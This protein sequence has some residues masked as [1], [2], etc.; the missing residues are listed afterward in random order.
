MVMA[1]KSISQ[2]VAEA[3]QWMDFKGVKGVGQGKE[4]G[5]NCIVV[6]VE[7]KTPEIEKAIPRKYE[8]YPVRI[9]ESGEI[10]ALSPETSH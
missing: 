6:F 8:G 3:S 4:H 5:K 9:E 10:R 2:A 7:I 1:R